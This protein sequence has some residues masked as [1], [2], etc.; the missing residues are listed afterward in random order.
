MRA[1]ALFGIGLL[2]L[3]VYGMA[4]AMVGRSGDWSPFALVMSGALAGLLFGFGL[5]VYLYATGPDA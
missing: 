4:V 2:V 5:T 3:T 1:V